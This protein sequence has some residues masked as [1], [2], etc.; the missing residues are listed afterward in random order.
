ME[1]R[2]G[3]GSGYGKRPLNRVEDSKADVDVE[4]TEMWVGGEVYIA[5]GGHQDCTSGNP[6][7]LEGIELHRFFIPNKFSGTMKTLSEVR[8]SQISS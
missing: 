3:A 8:W 1:R 4:E 7:D 5:H 2:L 6:S